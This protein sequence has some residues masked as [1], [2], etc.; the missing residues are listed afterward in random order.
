MQLQGIAGTQTSITG[1][2]SRPLKAM[3]LVLKYFKSY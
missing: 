2:V 1:A 3:A